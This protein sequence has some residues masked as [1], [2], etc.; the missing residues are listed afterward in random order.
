MDQF[1]FQY[2]DRLWFLALIPVLLLVYLLLIRRTAGRRR[3]FG[4][5]QLSR[6]LPRQ[7]AW[8]RHVAVTLALASL[9]S[10][11]LAFAM[12]S[13]EVNVPRERATVCIAIDVSLSMEAEDI[14]PNRLQAEKI[15]ASQFVD[16]LP[17]GFNAALVGFA[18]YGTMLVPPTTDRGLVKRAID[19]LQ[20]RPSTTIG[21]G[22]YSCLDALS[23]APRDE[24]RPDEPPPGAIVLLSDGASIPG[25]GRPSAQAAADAKA[26]KAPIYTIAYGTAGGYIM[27]SGI[28]EPVPV[29][30]AE[31]RR[32]ADISGGQAFT[33]G[34]AQELRQVYASIATQI[35]YEKQ[36][37][38]ITE[39]FA[40]AALVL[41]VLASLAVMSL[42]ARWP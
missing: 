37:R 23:L 20:L 21:E 13:G 34:S 36:Y 1:V 38:E 19:G 9:A 26:V 31:L 10:L 3:A 25:L 40:G 42:A 6:L 16:M 15:A 41:A 8:K 2:P 30:K 29:D 39:R 4:L 7:Q 11:T 12:P 35:G 22:I 17:T 32:I 28:R 33:A 27:R 5:D 14:E 18:G 24:R